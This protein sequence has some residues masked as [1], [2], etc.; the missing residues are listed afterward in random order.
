M[1]HTW[2]FS[3]LF[4]QQFKQFPSP[5]QDKIL[6]FIE[7]YETHGLSDFSNYEGKIT[8]SW[9]GDG[10]SQNDYAHDNS[11]WHYHIGIPDYKQR[12]P[13]YKTSD[14]VL[15]FQWENK[16]DHITIIDLYSHYNYD[17]E[18]YLPPEAYLET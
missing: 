10:I 1:A 7:T 2:S 11:L 16:G 13:A 5:D 9:S 4:A 14:W 15:H 18:F 8:P 3:I 17:G 12:H 6:D